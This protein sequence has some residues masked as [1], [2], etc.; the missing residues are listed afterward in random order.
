MRV[1]S[2]GR[3]T[4]AHEALTGWLMA[5]PAVLLLFTFLVLPFF[6]A[7]GFSL[8]NQRLFSPN[9]TEFVGLRNFESL[10]VVR[11]LRLEPLTDADTGEALRDDDGELR[12]PRL[13]SI[14]R[15][16]PDYPRYDGMRPVHSW[17]RGD[18][19]VFLLSRDVL[20]LRSLVNTIGFVA[21]VVPCQGGLAL[22]LALLLNNR[23]RGIVLFRTIYFMPVVISIVV[24]SLL[25][26]FMYD[27]ND[28]LL[29]TLLQ[30]LTFGAF[31]PVDWLGSPATAPPAIIM[32]SIWQAV[33]FHMVIWLAGLQNIPGSRY[34]AAS[35]DGANYLQQLRFVTWPGLRN[36]AVFVF[37]IITMQAFGLFT[38]IDVMT[39]GGPL[40]STQSMVYQI[41]ERGY[42]KQNIAGG[43]AMSV[44]YFVLVLAIS[45]TQ[46]FITRER[47]A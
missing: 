44:L 34:E 46:R 20:F 19:Q 42:R 40:D 33:G 15:N 5:A 27:G 23:R 17:Q 32:M 6:L 39:S 26:R 11:V 7:I 41:I 12:Y 18:T 28:G 47:R 38:Q 37:V 43:S 29:N 22:A 35:I 3:A 31:Q 1:R 36:T 24:V 2:A 8:T 16:N 30:A 25:W 10:L 13:R 21:I 45:L 9:P 4:F 14:T